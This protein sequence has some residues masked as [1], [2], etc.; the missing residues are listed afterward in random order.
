MTKRDSSHLKV[1][2]RQDSHAKECE[3]VIETKNLNVSFS[4]S[5]ALKNINAK[6]YENS[7]TSVIGPSGSG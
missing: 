7:V 1:V 5:H 3:I 6:F 4:K 2:D